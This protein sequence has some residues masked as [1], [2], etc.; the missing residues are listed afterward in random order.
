MKILPL[1]AAEALGR[2]FRGVWIATVSNIDW[3]KQRGLSPEV[4]QAQLIEQLD[5]AKEKNFNVV[6]FQIRPQADAFYRSDL[7]PW[8]YWLTNKDGLPDFFFK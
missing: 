4:A 5:L 2:E 6:V 7:E 3:P 1:L 8:S